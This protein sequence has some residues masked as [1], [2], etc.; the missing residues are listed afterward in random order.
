MIKFRIKPDGLDEFLVTAESRDIHRWELVTKGVTF[1]GLMES[2]SMIH[3]Y[4]IAY[5]AC[6]RQ[7][8]FE[9][10]EKDF[11]ETVD[12]TPTGDDAAVD[13]TNTDQ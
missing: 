1:Q 10:T 13:P 5:F 7:G 6:K 3:M 12:I 9:G 8:L 4:R 2:M 11:T